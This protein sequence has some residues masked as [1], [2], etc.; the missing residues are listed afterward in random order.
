MISGST[1]DVETTRSAQELS[2]TRARSFSSRRQRPAQGGGVDPKSSTAPVRA[3]IKRDSTKRHRCPWLALAWDVSRG[4]SQRS[5]VRLL[6]FLPTAAELAGRRRRRSSR[7]LGAARAAGARSRRISTSTSTGN[8]T[9]R[10][11]PA[12]RKGDWKAV[13][14]GSKGSLELYTSE[15]PCREENV[16]ARNR[17][18]SPR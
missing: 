4:H 1:A 3:R 16:A 9:R 17:K 5:G 8:S 13:R 6:G 7:H 18:S 2:S 10:V 14:H 11:S 12:I 15:R